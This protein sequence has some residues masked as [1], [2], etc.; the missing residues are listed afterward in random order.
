MK[1]ECTTECELFSKDSKNC[2]FLAMNEELYGLLTEIK[3]AIDSMETAVEDLKITVD[4]ISEK[5]G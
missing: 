2:T 5:M 3:F 4:E 1:C